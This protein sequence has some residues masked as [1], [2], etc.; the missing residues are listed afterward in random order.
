MEAYGQEQLEGRG[1][2]PS[3]ALTALTA[4]LKE[5]GAA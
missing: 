4:K 3:D 5:R 2:S 1:N